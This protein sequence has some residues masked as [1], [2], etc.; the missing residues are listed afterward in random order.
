MPTLNLT[1]N[2][3][4][5]LSGVSP[6]SIEK[7]AEEGIVTK[8]LI[9]GTL[10]PVR[11]AHVPMHIVAY[12]SV[13]KNVQGISMDIK[14]KRRL[15]RCIKDFGE[16]LGAFEPM[17]GFRL[18]VDTLAAAEWARARRY[19]VAKTAHLESREEIFGGEPVIKGTRITCRSV[20]GK[21]EGGDTIDDLMVDYPE[22]PREAF[23]A[24]VTYAKTHPRRGR[25]STGKP[26][27]Q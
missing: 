14:T 26:W 8:K 3:A 11:A 6:R 1:V 16:D 20:L 2:E 18:S 25:P 22:I 19:V 9:K 23:E 17:P 10:R 12:A 27:R 5:E 21:I 13:M 15:F 4:A 24:A 7:A